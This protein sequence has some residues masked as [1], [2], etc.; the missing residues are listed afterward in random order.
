MNKR[1]DPARQMAG[2]TEPL[3]LRAIF[4]QHYASI[5]RLLRR[6][7]VSPAQLDD[8]VQE[9]FWVAARRLTDIQPGREGPFLYGVALRIAAGE[10][11]RGRVGM[12]LVDIGELPVL[13]DE[14]PSPEEQ[15]AE[16]QARGLLDDVLGRMPIDLRTVFVL[17]ELEGLEVRQIAEL[18][19]IPV[20]TASSRLRRAREE[21][22]SIAKRVRAGLLARGGYGL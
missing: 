9:V 4:E 22:S 16:Q 17:F 13:V 6:L 1:A 19:E 11:R 3:E 2:K 10:L 15:L 8:A 7:G 14:R 5:W 21:F 18:E 12:P 20:G